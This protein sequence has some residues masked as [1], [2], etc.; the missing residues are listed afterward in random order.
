MAVAEGGS[1]AKNGQNRSI[2]ER[3]M[4]FVV[5]VAVA[6]AVAGV[7]VGFHRYSHTTDMH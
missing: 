6:V 3:Y 4:G 5:A 1:G 7:A 2:I